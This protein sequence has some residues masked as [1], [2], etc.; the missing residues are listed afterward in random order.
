MSDEQIE[1]EPDVWASILAY[2]GFES[3]D[4]ALETLIK[5][6]D[7]D[8]GDV[9]TDQDTEL[10]SEGD[11]GISIQ[12]Y[13]EDIPTRLRLA[14]DA[15][16]ELSVR[17]TVSGDNCEHAESILNKILEEIESVTADE[18]TVFYQSSREFVELELPIKES[19]EFRVTGMRL[20]HDGVDHIIQD[21]E[22]NTTATSTYELD[23]EIEDS[24]DDS[25]VGGRLEQTKTLIEEVL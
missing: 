19:T 11:E 5:L 12:F 4:D 24:V 16:N 10:D 9:F 14:V 23:E 6:R 8:F 18:I 7:V 13:H 17:L 15:D 21:R 22:S 20:D 3:T 25:F 1:D 2:G